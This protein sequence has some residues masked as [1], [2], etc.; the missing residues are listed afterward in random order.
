MRRM[1]MASMFVCLGVGP[2]AALSEV[3]GI[4]KY[5]CEKTAC[6][7]KCSGANTDLSFT[8]KTL[9]VFTWKLHSRRLWLTANDAQYVLGGRDLQV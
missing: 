2:A 8:Y 4:V 5:D 3:E 9:F 6:S 7:I 1:L